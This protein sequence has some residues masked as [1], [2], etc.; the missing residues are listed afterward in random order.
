MP[1]QHFLVS[2]DE[3]PADAHSDIRVRSGA[4]A[5]IRDAEGRTAAEALPWFTGR[6]LRGI[7]ERSLGGGGLN[8]ISFAPEAEGEFHRLDFSAL[9]CKVNLYETDA[10]I[11]MKRTIVRLCVA[12][13]KEKRVTFRLT[14]FFFA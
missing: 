9:S 14:Q 4:G 2:G 11:G 7:T 6:A 1:R 13:F 3:S 5:R 12:L 8:V 10:E